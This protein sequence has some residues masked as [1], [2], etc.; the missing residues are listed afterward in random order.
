MDEK[1]LLEP[2]GMSPEEFLIALD[3][4]EVIYPDDDRLE[5]A[6]WRAAHEAAKPEGWE[7]NPEEALQYRKFLVDLVM[8]FAGLHFFND[9]MVQMDRPLPGFAHVVENVLRSGVLN[10]YDTVAWKER[11]EAMSPAERQQYS[12]IAWADEQVR[13]ARA[14]GRRPNSTA[15]GILAR[16]GLIDE[17]GGILYPTFEGEA[18]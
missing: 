6:R 2:T 12:C 5:L 15:V 7:P 1:R 3:E 18:Q 14:V 10:F 4:Y 9:R 17:R 13:R 16:L 8:L 11:C